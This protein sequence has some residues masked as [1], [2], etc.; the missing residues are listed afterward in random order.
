MNARQRRSIERLFKREAQSKT[1]KKEAIRQ[2]RLNVTPEGKRLENAPGG[3]LNPFVREGKGR[4]SVIERTMI[5]GGIMVQRE[6]ITTR[7]KRRNVY[8][9]YGRFNQAAQVY[10]A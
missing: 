1:L 5:E 10:K 7:T 2:A 8:S 3:G 4:S 9:A 6:R